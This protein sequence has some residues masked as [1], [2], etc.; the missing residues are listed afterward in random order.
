LLGRIGDRK[1]QA[2]DG[3]RYKK[4]I[5]GPVTP[6]QKVILAV[7]PLLFAFGCLADSAVA[8]ES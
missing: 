5:F 6:A 4:M 3:R 2:T 1:R 7:Y 8:Q